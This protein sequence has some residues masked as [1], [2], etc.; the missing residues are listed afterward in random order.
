M[1]LPA[2]CVE[3]EY[4]CMRAMSQ[5]RE[6]AA[7]RILESILPIEYRLAKPI[8]SR[9]MGVTVSSGSHKDEVNKCNH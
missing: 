6:R 3:G 5:C 2:Q 4:A 9:L 8:Y 7:V 1:Y